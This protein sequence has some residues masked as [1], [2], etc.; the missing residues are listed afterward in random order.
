MSYF[1]RLVDRADGEVFIIAEACDNHMG[2]TRMAKALVDV[3]KASNADAVKFQ[4]HL[5]DEEM[6]ENQFST[7]NFDEPLSSFLQQ[8]AL[9]L[10]QHEEI[11]EY[12]RHKGIM[13]L[14]T[15][16]SYAAAQEISHLVPFFKIGSGEFQDY[17][18]IDRLVKLGLP[19]LFSCG[20]ATHEEISLWVK[21][22]GSAEVDT[23]L[24]NCLSEYPPDLA[25]M[26]LGYIKTLCKENL[27]IGHSDH[28]QILGGSITAV[29]NGARI[30]ERHITLS[31]FVSGPDASVSLT[32]SEFAQLVRELR[33]VRRMLGSK[34]SVNALEEPVRTWAYRSLIAV[35]D[36]EEG[37]QVTF[38]KLTTKRPGTGIPS[39]QY[40]EVIGKI[41]K[42]K[43][44]R[45]QMIQWEMLA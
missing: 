1:S 12:C 22:Y 38:E 24:L 25:D 16:F 7:E 8:N 21:R 44:N 23:A 10:H 14:C 26:N 11:A 20:M 32:P 13:Y 35:C 37:E 41:A 5:V 6:L 28:T 31:E 29:V 4:H 36:I 3:A 18:Y 27:I 15:P 9:S 19:C 33:V 30:I 17:V 42:Q 40:E 45:N 34:K 43:I 2:S 39:A